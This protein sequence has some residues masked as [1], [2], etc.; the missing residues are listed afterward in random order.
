METKRNDSN[1]VAKPKDATEMP[2][3]SATWLG[4]RRQGGDRGREGRPSSPGDRREGERAV[5]EVVAKV[6]HAGEEAEQKV[7]NRAKE[8]ASKADH[9]GQEGRR[10]VKRSER[11]VRRC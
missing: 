4:G 11:R 2:A 6:L 8:I 1:A 5:E 10:Q 9:H 3:N 7:V